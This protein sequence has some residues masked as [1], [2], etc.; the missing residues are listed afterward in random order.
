MIFNIFLAF[1]PLII[2][3]INTDYSLIKYYCRFSFFYKNVRCHFEF[4]VSSW[5]PWTA[6][7]KDV[8]ERV[9]RR[10][11][12]MISGLSGRNYE[13]K[14]KE[15]RQLWRKEESISTCY[16]HLRLFVVLMM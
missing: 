6:V 9:Q 14:L 2:L 12:N 10:A 13:D 7:H 11:V 3:K 1:K 4:S 15:L 8:L 16:K 5:C